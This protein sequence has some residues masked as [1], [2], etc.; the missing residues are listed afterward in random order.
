MTRQNSKTTKV[1]EL[2]LVVKIN[3]MLPLGTN[4]H[5]KQAPAIKAGAYSKGLASKF[6]SENTSF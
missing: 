5:I 4:C 6:K 1:R 3:A 2:C